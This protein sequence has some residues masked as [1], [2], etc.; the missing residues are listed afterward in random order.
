[1]EA[2]TSSEALR[3]KGRLGRFSDHAGVCQANWQ[4]IAGES[5]VGSR[6]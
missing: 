4:R 1:M 2:T 3:Q 5:P 6:G